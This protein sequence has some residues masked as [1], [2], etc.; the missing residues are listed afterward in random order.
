M[1]QLNCQLVQ[2]RK[3]EMANKLAEQI[4]R[5]RITMQ[6]MNDS[7]WK[8]LRFIIQVFLIRWVVRVVILGLI[9]GVVVI[10]MRVF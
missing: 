8:M 1:G 7:D 4:D 3:Q 9:V 5:I 10:C 2:G 6:L